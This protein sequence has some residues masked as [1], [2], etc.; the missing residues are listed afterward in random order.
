MQTVSEDMSG[1]DGVRPQARW[2]FA[3]ADLRRYLLRHWCRK[4]RATAVWALQM[5]RID[6]LI[7]NALA[8]ELDAAE[9]AIRAAGTSLQ[10]SSVDYGTPCL[11]GKLT[12]TEG[13]RSIAL[14]RPTRMGSVPVA[15]VASSLVA[16]MRPTCLAMSGVCAG[17]P[18]V[19][20]Q[21]DV[22]VAELA[23]AYDEG[24]RKKD[25]FEGDHRQIPLSDRWQR[26]AQ[27]LSL[28]GLST[29]G[30]LS[31]ED[32]K[33]WFIDQLSVGLNPALH[34][35]R[36]R[37]IEGVLWGETARLLEAEGLI[38]RDGAA[39]TL[40]Q[41]CMDAVDARRAYDMAPITRLPFAVHVGPIASGSAVVKDGVTWASL[42]AQGV[43]TAVG[44]E[45]EAAALAQVAHRLEVPHWIVVKGVMDY[46]DPNKEDRYKPFA[47]MASAQVLVRLLQRV[48]FQNSVVAGV[49]SSTTS[50]NIVGNVKGSNITISQSVAPSN[51]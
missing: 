41:S 42:K 32:R 11:I 22:I 21:G 16:Q 25:G 1:W 6:I 10:A 38:K 4:R 8:M 47:A 2:P 49:N 39:F 35:A 20:A 17:N 44:L 50:A 37:Y 7:V 40:T 36:D 48:P 23:Y 14:A 9:T 31:S 3:A 24:K 12:T 30:A 5:E 27:D 28:E 29:F 51:R 13:I 46:A 33:N 43:R 18:D 15:T 26:V 34:P 45:M 19:V